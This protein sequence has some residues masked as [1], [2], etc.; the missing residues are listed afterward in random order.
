MFH[1]QLCEKNAPA[2]YE[3]SFLARGA[4]PLEGMVTKWQH[5]AV[6]KICPFSGDMWRVRMNAVAVFRG[7]DSFLSLIRDVDPENGQW[8]VL[9]KEQGRFRIRMELLLTCR[10]SV[11]IGRITGWQTALSQVRVC[12]QHSFG[13]WKKWQHQWFVK[14]IT[15]HEIVNSDSCLSGA[16]VKACYAEGTQHSAAAHSGHIQSQMFQKKIHLCQLFVCF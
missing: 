14:K 13:D 4:D 11:N 5:R 8:R 3:T 6:I 12:E 15:K 9:P 1:Y 10:N 16:K 7:I 2:E